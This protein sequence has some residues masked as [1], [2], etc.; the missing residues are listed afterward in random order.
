MKEFKAVVGEN[1]GLYL[2][3][4][5]CKKMNL[6]PGEEIVMSYDDYSVYMLPLKQ[7]LQEKQEAE[8]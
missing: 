7:A 6:L 8:K 5:L 2:S 1:G 3:P 4:S